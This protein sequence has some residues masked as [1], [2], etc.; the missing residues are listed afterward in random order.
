[1]AQVVARDYTPVKAQRLADTI[2]DQLI[3]RIANGSLA[4]GSTLPPEADLATQFG[5]SRT[6]VREAVRTLVL[7]GLVAVKTRTGIQVRPPADWDHLDPVILFERV[8][9]GQ[10]EDLLDELLELRHIV[11]VES[12]ALA[13]LRRTPGDLGALDALIEAMR[14]ALDDPPTFSSWDLRFHDAILAA[15]HNRLLQQ[16]LRPVGK[17]LQVGRLISIQRTGAPINSQRGHEAIFAAIQ[18]GNQD[19]ARA[20]MHRHLT[21]FQGDIRISLR[22]G[23]AG[24]ITH[25]SSG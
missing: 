12:V 14:A 3:V 17:T 9:A 8:R 4:P 1:V 18:Q 7:K 6:V 25:L 20:A 15:A 13:A 10:D 11:E 19:L 5:V 16:A 21:Q 22:E 2:L 23:L 24:D